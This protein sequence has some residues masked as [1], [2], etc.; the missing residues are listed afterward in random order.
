MRALIGKITE[1]P[2]LP[3]VVYK[4]L[5]VLSNPNASVR[6]VAEVIEQDPVLS[7]RVLRL[8]N[9]GFYSVSGHT[10][11]IERAVTAIG[12]D[13]VSQLV[14]TAAVFSQFELNSVP[15]FRV[16]E[17]W[18]HSLGTAIASETIARQIGHQDPSMIYLAGLVHDIGKLVYHQLYRDEWLQLCEWARLE[19]QTIHEAEITLETI[20]HTELG[21]ELTRHWRLPLMIQDVALGHHSSPVLTSELEISDHVMAIRIV[22][23]GNLLVHSM[24]YGNS[25]HN[26]IRN[27]SKELVRRTLGSEAA[28]LPVARLVRA[29]L[30]RSEQLLTSIAGPELHA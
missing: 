2:T 8:A 15:S 13:S 21:Y 24:R 7:A 1:L 23:L 18:K 12:M 11:T 19:N 6:Q 27:P 14:F 22:H 9:S 3:Y 26:Q 16:R 5:Q 29:A 30:D 20:P 17:F 28:L 10:T 25:G 4:I